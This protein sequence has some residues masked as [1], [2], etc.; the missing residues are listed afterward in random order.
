VRPCLIAGAVHQA[1][2]TQRTAQSSS[3]ALSLLLSFADLVSSLQGQR[4]RLAA[5]WLQTLSVASAPPVSSSMCCCGCLC[6]VQQSGAWLQA[7]FLL[8]H[9]AWTIPGAFPKEQQRRQLQEKAS[10]SHT[11][12]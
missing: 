6:R 11:T 4:W 10:G 8:L 12:F 7:G 3:N 2:A 5:T 9:L 1:T